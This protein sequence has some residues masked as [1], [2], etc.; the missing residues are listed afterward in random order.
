[1][2]SIILLLPQSMM[3]NVFGLKR[4]LLKKMSSSVCVA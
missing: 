2:Y 3:G 4:L 1:M